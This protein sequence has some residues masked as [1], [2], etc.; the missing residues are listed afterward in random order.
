MPECR[1]KVSPASAFL[2]VVSYFNPASAF[3]HQGIG[4]PAS[5]LSPVLLVTD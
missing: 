1:E 5:G 4:I 3:R 2:P